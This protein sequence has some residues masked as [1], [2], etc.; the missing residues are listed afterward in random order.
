MFD[1]DKAFFFRRRNHA[2]IFD[3][4]RRGI[5]HVGKT[6]NKHRYSPC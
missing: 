4:R 2:T 5:T 3:E 6:E 1:S